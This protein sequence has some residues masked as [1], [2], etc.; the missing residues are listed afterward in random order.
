MALPQITSRDY[1]SL[2]AVTVVPPISISPISIATI[3]IIISTMLPLEV[4]HRRN[5]LVM[6]A[7]QSF[8]LSIQGCAEVL[9]IRIS[10]GKFIQLGFGGVSFKKMHDDLWEK[11]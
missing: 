4:I 11:R 7:F 5:Q 10:G 1:R 3:S 8:I 6:I 9:E 2:V